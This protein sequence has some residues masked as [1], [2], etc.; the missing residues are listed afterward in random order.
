MKNTDKESKKKF[1]SW[2]YVVVAVVTT[3]IGLAATG[4]L[5]YW[6]AQLLGG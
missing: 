4:T 1:G 5:G 3:I 6:I 2:I